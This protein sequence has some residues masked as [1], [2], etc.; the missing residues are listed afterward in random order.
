MAICTSSSTFSG[1]MMRRAPVQRWPHFSVISLPTSL[2]KRSNSSVPGTASGT[3][4][5]GVEAVGLH[6]EGHALV[7]DARVLL[8]HAARG[9][10]AGEGDHVLAHHMIQQITGAADDQLQGAFGQDACWR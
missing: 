10:A 2:M 7:D 3:E 4:H 5:D 6:V 8:Q 1:T 9:G